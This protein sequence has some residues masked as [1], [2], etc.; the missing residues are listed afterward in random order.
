MFHCLSVTLILFY[1]S[2]NCN[3]VVI[4]TLYTAVYYKQMKQY[5]VQYTLLVTLTDQ[6]NSCTL[7][8]IYTT[9][10]ATS[11]RN[12]TLRAHKCTRHFTILT[13]VG[14]LPFILTTGFDS[15]IL[16]NGRGYK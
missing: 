9:H 5:N 3:P 10:V 2:F 8:C 13:L 16:R 15:A 6:F 12:Q 14:S 11:K 4:A 7:T 1:Y